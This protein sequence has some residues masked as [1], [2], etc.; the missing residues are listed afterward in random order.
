MDSR[1]RGNDGNRK[2]GTPP[3]KS[4]VLTG[5]R[6]IEIRET[7]KPSIKHAA[8]VLLKIAA[9]GVCGSDVHYFRTGQIGRQVV[10]FP[11][12][13]GHE[14]SAVVEDAGRGVMRVQPGDRVFVDPAVPCWK[15]DQC[16]AGRPH[17]CRN[18][19]FLGCPGQLDGSLSEYLVLPEEC[20]HP[21]SDRVT[22]EQAA[23]V[24]PLSIG[25][26]ATR[27]APDLGKKRV[28]VLGTGPIGLSVILSAMKSGASA[29][30][31]TD[32]LEY[33]LKTAA[34]CGAVWTGN[35][36]KTDVVGEIAKAEPL[37]L[38]VVFECCGEQEALDQGIEI[39]KPGGSLIIAGIPEVPRIGFD[40]DWMRRKEI[41]VRNVR[42]Q[43]G[44]V[45]PSLEWMEQ[46]GPDFE[47]M[48]THRFGLEDTQKAF[49]LVS[50]YKDGVIKA[51]VMI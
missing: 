25:M 51:M 48:I 8:D 16:L 14:C 33:R 22:M 38:D 28:G 23:L 27:L 3:M 43:N 40:I 7:P 18:L 12:I 19:D 37:L 15:C 2:E 11:F 17:T 5:I 44:C 31:A 29:V 10:R 26:Y 13:V 49:D 24:E 9:T 21:V 4:A 45:E 30:Y 34:R 20:C 6:Q 32:K 36:L 39:L 50:E 1:F 35:P 46:S 42:R 41:T 47:F